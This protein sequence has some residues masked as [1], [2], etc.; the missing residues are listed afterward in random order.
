MQLAL[1][2]EIGAGQARRQFLEKILFDV[3]GAMGFGN[4]PTFHGWLLMGRAEHLG[5]RQRLPAAFPFFRASVVK[6]DF[7]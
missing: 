4:E 3:I 5:A 1:S 2:L 6:C 7:D